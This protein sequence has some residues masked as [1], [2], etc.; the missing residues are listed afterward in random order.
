MSDGRLRLLTGGLATVGVGIAAYLSYTRASNTALICPTSG[1]ARVQQSAYSEI[2]G[3][4]IAYL[5][6]PGYAAILAA[7]AAATRRA[8]VAEAALALLSAAFAGYLLALQL[9]VIDAVCVW[10]LASDVV[11]FAIVLLAFARLRGH[12]G[13]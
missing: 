2:A 3:I 8:A 11:I 9:F 7:A 5:G 13:S 10:C 6:I 1:C 4:P 12:R